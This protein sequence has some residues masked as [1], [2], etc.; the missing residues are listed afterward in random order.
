MC[1]AEHHL[2]GVADSDIVMENPAP[3]RLR[4][5][6]QKPL[7]GLASASNDE[8][9]RSQHRGLQLRPCQHIEGA[10]DDMS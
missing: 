7:H 8:L 1:F 10:G 5:F 4:N 3:R 9:M 6:Q 2:Q